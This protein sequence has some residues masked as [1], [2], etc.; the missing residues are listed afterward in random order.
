MNIRTLSRLNL[1]ILLVFAVNVLAAQSTSIKGIIT[2]AES[3]E[4]L[5]GVKVVVDSSSGALT[6]DNGVYEVNVSAGPHRVEFF[7]SGYDV[8][9]KEVEVVEGQTLTLDM[10]VGLKQTALDMVVITGS[11]YEKK[12]SEEVVSVDVIK[13]YLIENNISVDIS[14]AVGK[15]PGVNIIDGQASIR[16]S[17]GYSFGAGTRVLVLLDDVPV[18]TTDLNDVPWRFIPQ[19]LVDQVEV[20]KGMAAAMYG[21]AAMNGVINVRTGYASSKPETKINFFQGV[22]MNPARREVRWWKDNRSPFETGLYISHRRRI[23]ENFDLVL[24]GNFNG[25]SPFRQNGN[26]EQGRFSFKTRYKVPTKKGLS[27]GVN[28]ILQYQQYTRFI[29]WQDKNEGAYKP[30]DGTEQTE[31]YFL[32]SI[33][34]HLTYVTEKGGSHTFRSRIYN[35]YKYWSDDNLN[36]TLVNAKYQYTKRLPWS[37]TM[38]AGGQ[39]QVSTSKSNFFAFRRLTQPEAAAFVQLE[40]KF[41]NKLSVVLG[42]RY[43][44][45]QQLDSMTLGLTATDTVPTFQAKAT[46]FLP[47][48]GLNY[49]FGKASFLRASFGTTYRVPAFAEKFIE[50]QLGSILKFFPNTTL[51][52]EKGIAGVEL[53]LKQGVQV[54]DWRGYL[55]LALFWN[56]FRD[57]TNWGFIL[58]VDPDGDII[59]GFRSEN[60]DQARIMGYEVSGMGEGKLGPIPLRFFGGY[61]FHY[62][63]D[64]GADTTQRNFGVF[65]KNMAKSMTMPD[66]VAS[67][68]LTYRTQHQVRVDLEA[69][70][71][72]FTVGFNMTYNSFMHRIDAV[73]EEFVP[74]VKDF[75]EEHHSGNAIFNVRASYMVSD[76]SRFTLVVKN[77][78]NTEYSIRPAMLEAP[79][80]FNLQYRYTF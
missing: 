68:M 54:G 12:I 7:Y 33:D 38:L 57:M 14:D 11:Q 26:N 53:G 22:Y 78:A 76:H 20:V 32:S 61:T 35:V 62:G 23:K 37:L 8:K 63:G 3:K 74:G 34:P 59:F 13:P 28:G 58:K 79:A 9:V 47:R 36:S 50:T 27:L 60:V 18:M 77:V 48:V 72:K 40:K 29:L 4:T 49:Q 67:S 16:G 21:S 43:G 31:R 56:E 66:S 25:I 2:D 42:G 51:K 19:E 73:F 52:P 69:D 41:A 5:P 45:Y 55:D 70:L 10:E 75:R 17:S 6:D 80:S 65:F 39:V 64:L 24:G 71:W 46:P 1:F 15:V 30:L 44:F